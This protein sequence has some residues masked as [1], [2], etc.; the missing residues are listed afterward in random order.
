MAKLTRRAVVL[1]LVLGVVVLLLPAEKAPPTGQWLTRSG[2]KPQVVRL[3]RLDVRYVRKGQGPVV[4]LIHGL[5]SSIYSWAD[6]MG[7][8][9]EKFDVVALDLPGFG[10]SSQPADLSFDDLPAA[11][12]GLMD[13]LQI[14]KAHLVGNSMGG[15]VSVL[16]AA[17]KRERVDRL[18]ILDSA[19]FNMR[20]GERP[21]M[22]KVMASRAAGVL[23]GRLPVRRLLTGATVRHLFHDETR[24]T[25]ERI[26]EYVAPLLR[27][28][29]LEST[30]SLL[31]SRLDER[32]AADLSAI[33][34][35]T[36]VVWGR[37]DPWLPEAHADRFVAGI[38]GARKVV[39][40]TG[41]LPQEERPAEVARLIGD[42]LIS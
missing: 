31:L 9:S 30:R 3:G 8:L 36:L 24:V 11:V 16:L 14:P 12:I 32:F 21:F 10:A 19:G 23:A 13:T 34:A 28:G 6:V 39:L 18:V 37:F 42:F 26:D 17:R 33:E 15:A 20:P 4:V 7:P 29:A 1:L 5:A 35:K 2:L 27:P 22:V 41:H 40:D 25:D 38:K